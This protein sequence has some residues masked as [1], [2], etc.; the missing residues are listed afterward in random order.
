MAPA[1]AHWRGRAL[2]A[3]LFDLD[4]TLLD[5]V[6]AISAALN[7]A[8]AERGLDTVPVEQVRR[9]IGRG[10]PMLIVRALAHLGVQ[11]ESAEQ[12][13]LLQRYLAHY[14]DI[15]S[16]AQSSDALY[17]GVRECLRSL[18]AID[19]RLAVVTNKPQQISIG[20]LRRL[21]LNRWID[22]V[23]GGDSCERRKPDPQPLLLACQALQVVSSDALMIGDSINDV[24]AARAAGM[25]VL[26]VPYGYNEGNDP[27][28]LPCDS[29]VE[30]LADVP[31]L[32]TEQWAPPTR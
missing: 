10:A 6:E 16:G 3:V 22:A 29:L 23:I 2:R 12:A 20:L 26:C 31:R 24:Q 7:R 14:H 15:E 28:E 1:R 25:P 17:A 4:G 21:D 32:L 19:L 8:L 18:A 11:L 27:R 13:Q 9:M 5:T 30:T